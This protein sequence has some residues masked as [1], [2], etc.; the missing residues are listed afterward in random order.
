MG[1]DGC[2]CDHVNII[3]E[4]ERPERIHDQVFRFQGDNVVPEHGGGATFAQLTQFHHQTRDWETR[5]QLQDDLVEH[6]WAHVDNQ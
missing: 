4:D 1:G 5:I 3:V 2:L 6:M